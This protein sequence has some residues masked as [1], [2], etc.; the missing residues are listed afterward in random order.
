MV[1]GDGN[2]IVKI[3]IGDTVSGNGSG[4]V[5]PYGFIFFAHLVEPVPAED[6]TYISRVYGFFRRYAPAGSALIKEHSLD[7]IQRT[8]KLVADSPPI[9]DKGILRGGIFY[10]RIL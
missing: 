4:I 9:N 5:W 8:D 3:D 6:E 1:E 10:G 2:N 7:L